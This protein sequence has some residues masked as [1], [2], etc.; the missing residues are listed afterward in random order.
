MGRRH[1][2]NA[3]PTLPD[4]PDYARRWAIVNTVN[5]DRY[6]QYQKKTERPIS[7]VELRPASSV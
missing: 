6:A 7:I 5:K 2:A 4:D 3:R 1:R